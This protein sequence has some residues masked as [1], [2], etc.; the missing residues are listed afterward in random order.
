MPKKILVIDN[1][2]I[3]LNFMKKLLEKEGHAVATAED[4]LLAL[5]LIDQFQ[6]DIIFTDL[7]MPNIEGD[8]LCEI[9]RSSD[10]YDNCYLVLMSAAAVEINLDEVDISADAFIAKGPF[11]EMSRN[12]LAVINRHE[13][14]T[15]ADGPKQVVGLES[16]YPRQMTQKL[17]SSNN[18]L[19]TIIDSISEGILEISAGRIVYANN[20]ACALF[21]RGQKQLLSLTPDTLFEGRAADRVRELMAAKTTVATEIGNRNPIWLAGKRVIL[22]SLPVLDDKTTRIL[23]ITDETERFAI[24]KELREYRDHLE[25]LVEKRTAELTKTTEKLQQAQ[26]L[27][28]IG[29][30]AGGV[31]HDLNNVLSGILS[32][33]ELLLM[34][35][36]PD[37]PLVKPMQTIQK[38]G[39]KA[40]AIVQDL[41][42]LA[43]RGVSVSKV[44]SMNQT[45]LAHLDSPE[46]QKLQTYHPSVKIKTD[47]KTDLPN[48]LGS[49]IH[50]SKTLMNLISNAAE[51]MPA[52]GT[53]TIATRVQHL[54]S[55]I[56]GHAD[57]IT[58]DYVQVTVAD[59]GMGISEKEISKIF[60]P[61]YTK[62][63]MGRSGTG[64]GMAV[65]WG[66]VKDHLGY[67]DIKSTLEKGT[68]FNLYFPI[69]ERASRNAADLVSIE[70]IK[71]SGETVLVVDDMPEQ[72]E[73]ASGMLTE[74]GYTATTVTSGSAA[75]TYMQ[76]HVVDLLLLD[77]I[78]T[79]GID[80][81]ETYQRILTQ[82]PGQKA[83]I[84][85]GFSTTERIRKAQALGAG[86]FIRKPFSIRELGVAVRQTLMDENT[87]S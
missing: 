4:G 54:D 1:N 10:S 34:Q 17:L 9:V 28:A 56:D 66:T 49:P 84:F 48:I 37:S 21:G 51:A 57:I 40:A 85:S 41:L 43:R 53:I 27:E 61:F 31:A 45:I 72:L 62:K 68:T 73:I 3:I 52:G 71:G 65:V 32:Y 86:R 81:L 5:N 16:V 70:S 77:M 6:P 78:M 12:I 39:E 19:R 69:T 25:R 74:L 2:R 83:V 38:S 87:D 36:A 47:L 7:I 44:V 80:G 26:K 79:P 64:L 50:L 63:A 75:V 13:M 20:T 33:P 60:E 15:D 59:T 35:I 67:I 29:T 58:G 55:P 18:H 76:D 14:P 22:Q 30:L 24:E 11:N 8:K 82:H 46:F 42:T 23:M